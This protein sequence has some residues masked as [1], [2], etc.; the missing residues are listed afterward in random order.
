MGAGLPNSGVM[1]DSGEVCVEADEALKAR[2]STPFD[3]A[4]K[5]AAER[6]VELLGVLQRGPCEELHAVLLRLAGGALVS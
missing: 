3:T 4:F 1:P 5:M 2:E 6:F